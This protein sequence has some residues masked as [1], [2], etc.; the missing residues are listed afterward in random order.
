MTTSTH[1]HA[2][3]CCRD[4]FPADELNGN[5]GKFAVVIERAIKALYIQWSMLEVWNGSYDIMRTCHLPFSA[6]YPVY[7]AFI[8]SV[9]RVF[10][11][12]VGGSS[13]R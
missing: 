2:N 8:R 13:R 11:R 4:V 7:V 9:D 3:P 1:Q 6:I 5:H 10:F 12:F